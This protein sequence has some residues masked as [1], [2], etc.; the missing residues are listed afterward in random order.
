MLRKTV[1]LVLMITV[2]S[3]GAALGDVPEVVSG[4]VFL[5]ANANGRPDADEK[6]IAGARVTDGVNFVTTAADGSYKLVV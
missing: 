6:G 3:A 1:V 2:P 4:K 5:D